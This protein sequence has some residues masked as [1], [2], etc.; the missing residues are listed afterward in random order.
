VKITANSFAPVVELTRGETVES[1][2]YGAIVVVDPKGNL[3]RAYGDPHVVTF[4]RSAAKPFQALPFIEAGGH[5]HYHLTQEEIAVICASHSGTD[6][7]AAVVL[8][9]QKKAGLEEGQLMCGAH[10]PYDQPTADAML[11]RG[12]KPT[13]NRHNCSG[14]H[15]GMLAFAKMNDEPLENYLEIGHPVQQRI[16]QALAD[17]SGAPLDEIHLG[18]D[19][20]S[21]PNF[22]LSLYHAAWA[23]A[24]LADPSG[25]SAERA[26]ACCTISAAMTACPEMVSGPG[27]FDTVVMEAGKGG[28]LVK[29]GAEGYQGI[30]ILPGAIEPGSPALGVAIKI[31]DG[32]GFRRARSAVSI[33]VLRQ[34]GALPAEEIDA[35]KKFG[36]VKPVVNW[37]KLEVGEMRPVFELN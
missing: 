5:R 18:T 16:L 20:C 7:H 37:R 9:I 25:L 12:E 19:G 13:A 3:V 35:L 34:L 31:A 8:S 21:A 33:E 10:M 24:R 32:D 14:K 36:P 23:W 29:A 6:A 28:L 30:G 22:A 2:H 15:T 17:L 27:E 11:L 26:E 4:L 1:I